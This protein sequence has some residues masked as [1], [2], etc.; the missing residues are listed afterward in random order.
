MP[1]TLTWK[2]DDDGRDTRWEGGRI[3]YD[4]S[5]RATFII[6]RMVQGRR[7][8]VS[9]R[10][11]T[12][13]A[14]LKHLPRFEADP[15][16]YARKDEEE[17]AL[18]LTEELQLEF[19]AH[20][21][22][23]KKNVPN[24]VSTQRI[25]LKVWGEDL[26][27]VDLR[28]LSLGKHIDTALEKRG[29]ARAQRIKV[30][31]AMMAWLRK[32]KRLVVASQDATIDLPVPQARPE[33]AKRVKAVAK[34]S[35][36]KTL[37][38]LKGSVRDGLM[39]LGATGCHYSELVRFIREGSIEPI[40]EGS[41]DGVAILLFQHKSGAPHRVRIQKQALA[42][43]KRL[44]ERGKAWDPYNFTTELAEACERAGV[45]TF[46]AGQLRHSVA[47]WAVNAGAD[48]A[49]V[50]SF[51][52]HRSVTTMTKFYATHAAPKAVPTLVR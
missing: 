2:P 52:G 4:K 37:K 11:H 14:A 16:A 25:Y 6:E 12:V 29:N 43:A 32:V 26:F 28:R 33:Q 36:E 34:E 9:T 35:F 18:Y 3:R 27:G 1:E 38:E 30:L 39:V 10:A 48:P 22:D 50:A 7:F 21:R 44:K 51:L 49:A 8:M 20:S 17:D 15:S 19:L 13:S 5:G 24:W 42:A 31:K 47:T 40:P 46:H 41:K 23:V 45:P